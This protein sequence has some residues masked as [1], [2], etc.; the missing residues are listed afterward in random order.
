M[1]VRE[2]S[3]Y[4]PTKAELEEDMRIPDATPEELAQALFGRHPKRSS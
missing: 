2:D 3:S 1:F 4:Q